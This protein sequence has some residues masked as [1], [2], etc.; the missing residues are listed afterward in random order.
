[1]PVATFLLNECGRLGGLVLIVRLELDLG[2]VA[3]FIPFGRPCN[4]IAF[5]L[6]VEPRRRPAALG[7]T[8]ILLPLRNWP[9]WLFLETVPQ[10]PIQN[11]E[12][13]LTILH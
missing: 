9:L 2:N 7:F 8:G 1:M 12:G 13:H 4:T 5:P 10:I 6:E 3:I 11:G